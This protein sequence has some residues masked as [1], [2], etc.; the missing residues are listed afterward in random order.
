MI[1]SGYKKARNKEED[2]KIRTSIRD[3]V[4][5][6][7]EIYGIPNPYGKEFYNFLYNRK[8]LNF[9]S[10]TEVAEKELNGCY[11]YYFQTPHP[12]RK[13]EKLSIE[14]PTVILAAKIIAAYLEK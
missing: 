8:Y 2:A 7:K 12:E 5:Y 9:S 6:W 10:D 4:E 3:G 14:V 13:I 11:E 1:R